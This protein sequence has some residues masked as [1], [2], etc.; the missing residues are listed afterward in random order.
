VY[1]GDQGSQSVAIVPIT[2]A[3]LEAHW[4]RMNVAL[5]MPGWNCNKK[6]CAIGVISC[7]CLGSMRGKTVQVYLNSW[8][9]L[10]DEQGLRNQ[11]TVVELEVGL[12]D[13]FQACRVR[14]RRTSGRASVVYSKYRW[15]S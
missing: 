10:P 5:R 12:Q 11:R 13:R 3:V 7:P 14:R 4:K 9:F 15:K 6:P 2:D 1:S 8:F